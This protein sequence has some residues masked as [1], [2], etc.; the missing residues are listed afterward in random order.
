M[1][2]EGQK[3]LY[4]D[5]EN[6]AH[7]GWSY[8]VF[9]KNGGRMAGIKIPAHLISIQY[10]WEGEDKV[11]VKSLRMFPTFKDDYRDDYLLAKHAH[12]LIDKADIVVAFNG[13]GHDIPF[14]NWR[15]MVHKMKAP[16]PYKVVDPY[17][18]RKSL[19][20]NKSPGN[21][22][23]AVAEEQGYTAKLDSVGWPIWQKCVDDRVSKRERLD[24]YREIEI[25]GGGDIAPLR[26]AY[27]DIRG[28]MPNH[29]KDHTKTN[30]STAPICKMP[31]C[32]GKCIWRGY[33][34]KKG[35]KKERRF[36]CKECGSYDQVP[37]PKD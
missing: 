20:K 1:K 35:G 24:A 31:H 19:I 33:I 25:Y 29:P 13:K 5:I 18:V 11:H 27:L 12:D 2:T 23:R 36:Q 17:Q 37:V 21:S 16:S 26:Q 15:F 32:D 3:L 28:W 22:L 8:D 4:L 34:T 6:T 7:E 14:L 10:Q 9:F 30:D